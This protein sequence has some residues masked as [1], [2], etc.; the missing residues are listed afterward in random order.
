[1]GSTSAPK[2]CQ[3]VAYSELAAL[4]KRI[5]ALLGN[6]ELKL[7]TSI[8]SI[9]NRTPLTAD[10]NRKVI[11]D[12][13]PNGYLPELI[14][15]N[16]ETTVRATLESH[17]ISPA[18]FDILLRSPFGADDFE[19]FL[20]ERQRTIQEAIED[21]LVKERLDLPPQLR[22]LD[23]Q[24]EAIELALRQTICEALGGDATKLPPHVQQRVNERLQAAAKKNAALDANHY[25]TLAGKL[26]Y[27]DLRDLQDTVASKALGRH[28]QARF[29]NKETLAKRFDQLA[30]LRNGIRHS[31]R[32]DEVTRKEGEAAILW[33][34][35]LLGQ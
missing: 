17:F 2:D 33:F 29:S 5:D 20:A 6:G 3:T 7:D 28:F 13:L 19:A 21:L 25:A 26:E 30:E 8:D 15:A 10:T 32:V 14:A 23:A 12:R 4:K 11:G 1:M 22:V 27:A 34:E 31:R 35:H 9:L 24:I 16:G 18:A